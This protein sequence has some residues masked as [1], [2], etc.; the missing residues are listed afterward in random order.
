MNKIDFQPNLHHS[1]LSDVPSYIIGTD[2]TY[3]Q[4]SS[5]S[6]IINN[7]LH[8]N[9]QTHFV[10]FKLNSLDYVDGDCNLTEQHTKYNKNVF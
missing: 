4:Q 8:D 2:N 5:S 7:Q 6:N 1:R 10:T 9:L 3:I